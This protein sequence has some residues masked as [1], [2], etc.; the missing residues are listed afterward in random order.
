MSDFINWTTRR[1]R[2]QHR[3]CETRR[4]IAT[5]EQYWHI[6]SAIDGRGE[7][8]EMSIEAEKLYSELHK[9]YKLYEDNGIPFGELVSWCIYESEDAYPL[10]RLLEIV[11]DEEKR[12]RIKKAIE[13]LKKDFPAR[14]EKD[15]KEAEEYIKTHKAEGGAK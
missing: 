9:R 10:V 5:G 14:T 1:A 3:C 8:H 11:S 13:E 12:E 15:I 6:F 4:T 7:T 2:K